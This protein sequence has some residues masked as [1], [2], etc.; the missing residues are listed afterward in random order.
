MHLMIYTILKRTKKILNTKW[1]ESRRARHNSYPGPFLEFQQE[2]RP[3]ALLEGLI[4]IQSSMKTCLE[5]I[6]YLGSLT[7]REIWLEETT[8]KREVKYFGYM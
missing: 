8:K 4:R 1:H 7:K 3:R 2:V 5:V 6:E